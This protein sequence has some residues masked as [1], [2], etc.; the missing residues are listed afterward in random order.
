MPTSI[1]DL[2]DDTSSSYGVVKLKDGIFFGDET[3]SR[4]LDFLIANKV[5]GIINCCG[6][7]V[8]N[9]FQSLGVEY[10]TFNWADND[11]QIILDLRNQVVTE[12]IE[13]ISRSLEVGESVLIFSQRGKSRCITLITAY[14]MKTYSWSL[15]KAL[16]FVQSRR[17]D[18]K[19]KPNFHR[20]L[21]S[22]ERRLCMAG[23]VLSSSWDNPPKYFEDNTD[24]LV[25]FNTFLNSRYGR[26]KRRI[27]TDFGGDDVSGKNFGTQKRIEWRDH[28]TDDRS[29][30]EQ[31]SSSTGEMYL[32]Q[33]PKVKSILKKSKM[34]NFDNSMIPSAISTAATTPQQTSLYRTGTPTRSRPA[35]PAP[36]IR[37]GPG[38]P[39]I[40]LNRA[41]F[42]SSPTTVSRI[43]SGI[44]GIATGNGQP[45]RVSRG[46]N[47]PGATSSPVISS[48]NFPLS[49]M[50]N[51]YVRPPSPMVRH[52][53]TT[54]SSGGVR[55]Q[56]PAPQRL[57]VA[58]IRPPSPVRRGGLS[59]N[60]E[61]AFFRPNVP[62][63]AVKSM[64]SA[65][66]Y[67]RSQSPMV[68]SLPGVRNNS[69]RSR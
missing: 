34:K 53:R 63:P 18:I 13:F 17:A 28:F 3:A 15:N 25:L 22:F 55:P 49:Q 33:I 65:T 60:N 20:Q 38:P 6:R 36:S 11:S 46:I 30:L 54:P 2:V 7:Q 69:W 40:L 57:S 47:S 5:S 41:N 31:V 39:P 32:G 52:S 14:L 29:R 66:G 35:S 12:V 21:V 26:S 50:S 48:L 1:D 59:L 44:S 56:S 27:S 37:T 42:L 9:H 58:P 4:D 61:S 62:P 43:N 51:H 24:E 16:E 67:R 19:I 45:V 8:A 23:I 68:A 64:V 10:L